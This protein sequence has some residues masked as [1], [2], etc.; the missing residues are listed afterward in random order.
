[1][2]MINLGR[3][4][5]YRNFKY[6]QTLALS[7]KLFGG[8]LFLGILAVAW[9]Q[10]SQPS[11]FALTWE[12]DTSMGWNLRPSMA[13]VSAMLGRP[14]HLLAGI[15]P[16]SWKTILLIVHLVGLTL[17][18]GSALFL[19]LFLIR[20]LFLRKVQ[21][22]TYDMVKFGSMLASIGLLLLWMSGAGFLLI[23]WNVDPKMLDNPKIW[24]KL[25]I[26]VLLSVNGL[27]IHESLLSKI[28]NK[29]G[30]HLLEGES[31]K[32]IRLFALVAS[33]SC[34]SWIAAMVL[35]IAKELNNVVE[36][37]LLLAIYL[38]AIAATYIV[39]LG[40]MNYR[41]RHFKSARPAMV[42]TNMHFKSAF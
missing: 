37:G 1:M 21:T 9:W 35:G 30:F 18:F 17:G 12:Y 36:G 33:V 29:S 22:N 40:I 41:P 20:F 6:S 28:K 39:F 15:I 31:H 16:I 26:V 23:Y 19:D 11:L 3:T 34:N 4:L 5:R 10:L 7:F 27:V 8:M 2:N 24:A 38:C 25:V 32:T 14:D 42:P 13:S